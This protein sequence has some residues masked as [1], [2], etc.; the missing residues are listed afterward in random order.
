MLSNKLCKVCAR[1]ANYHV[2]AFVFCF[3]R[4]SAPGLPCTST[5]HTCSLRAFWKQGL[6]VLLGLGD[7]LFDVVYAGNVCHG[8]L[9]AAKAL[10]GLPW[11]YE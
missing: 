5:C 8:L 2:A 9:L 10:S 11:D 4:V 6:P 7:A 1:L 3:L